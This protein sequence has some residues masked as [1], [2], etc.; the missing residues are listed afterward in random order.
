[1][2]SPEHIEKIASLLGRI[3]LVSL[4]MRLPEEVRRIGITFPQLQCLLY[5]THHGVS[6]IGEIATGLSISHPA[7]VRM[8]GRL[9][10]KGLVRKSTL[11]SDRRVSEVELTNVGCSMAGIVRRER[12]QPIE[13]GLRD[14]SVTEREGLVRGLEK[15][16]ASILKDERVVEF[17]CLRCGEQHDGECVINRAHIALTGA[18]IERP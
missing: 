12:L 10:R 2:E 1:M 6:S 14:L 8:V 18:G 15:L 9:E 3:L 5:L 16:V 13:D 4:R 17:A 11:D 7:A